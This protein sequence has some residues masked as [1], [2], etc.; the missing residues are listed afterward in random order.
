MA[1]S[2]LCEITNTGSK[3]TI[4]NRLKLACAVGIMR[5][6]PSKGG[7]DRKSNT[8][9]LLGKERDWEPMPMD[10]PG[11]NPIIAL[12]QVRRHN[13]QLLAK[14]HDL[15]ARIAHLEAEVARLS[16]GRAI[17]HVIVINGSEPL[18]SGEAIGRDIVTNGAE[19]QPT[20]EV[21]RSYAG[22]PA[23]SPSGDGESIG[24]PRVTNGPVQEPYERIPHS[25]ETAVP[26]T[27]AE[28]HEAIG[29]TEVNNGFDS[30]D[31]AQEYLARHTQVKELVMK[32]RDY[33]QQSFNRRGVLG[34]I[35]YFSRSAEHEQDLIR[36]VGIL[37]A[38]G[39]PQET[40]TDP[41]PEAEDPP[42]PSVEPDWYA[43]GECPDYG[44][45]FGTSPLT[46]SVMPTPPLVREAQAMPRLLIGAPAGSPVAPLFASRPAT[47]F[48]GTDSRSTGLRHRR[49][50][51]RTGAWSR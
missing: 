19:S 15:T 26:D 10:R 21:Y 49:I 29:H 16:N 23:R 28:P 12:A 2:T 39:E 40:G 33:Y 32:Y 44:R 7:K 18:S 5:K 34:A 51:G 22:P 11:T 27:S 48:P 38:G 41:P 9:V 8:C 46:K 6:E 36:Q 13:E 14:N 30:P 47:P 45:P 37:E 20:G 50:P 43:V 31:E 42:Q 17:G 24:Y 1:V 4:E 3:N 25:Y 35:E